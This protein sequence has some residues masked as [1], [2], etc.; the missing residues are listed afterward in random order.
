[1]FMR[2]HCARNF[3]SS[4]VTVRFTK[5]SL[6]GISTSSRV[7]LPAVWKSDTSLCVSFLIAALTAPIFFPSRR[8]S[9]TPFSSS[10]LPLSFAL[11]VQYFSSS[12]LYETLWTFSSTLMYDSSVLM[13]SNTPWS[14]CTMMTSRSGRF[15][16]KSLPR[17]R[18]PRVITSC[19]FAMVS[20]MS[21]L[22][23]LS[24]K[25]GLRMKWTLSSRSVWGRTSL[26]YWYSAKN[27]VN[28]AMSFARSTRTQYRTL[29]AACV[30]SRGTLSPFRRLRLKRT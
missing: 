26:R 13:L 17:A 21:L 29:R 19:M 20:S 18:R 11:S 10:A 28:G 24:S 25:V 4:T 14:S 8:P 27:G 23:R 2:L 22:M 6:R 3:V 5:T 7:I 1:M 12:V 15:T 30:S 16:G 9:F